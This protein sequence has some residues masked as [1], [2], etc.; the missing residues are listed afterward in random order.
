MPGNCVVDDASGGL[1][2]WFT[3]FMLLRGLANGHLQTIVGSFLP[4]QAFGNSAIA[5]TVEVD[6]A[7]RSRVLCHCHWQPEPAGRFTVVLVHGLESSSNS[8]AI[9]GLAMRAW[10]LTAAC[11]WPLIEHVE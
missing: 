6:P 2:E 7:D 4:P 8:S 11:C 3:P 10:A 5:K 1:G 9:L